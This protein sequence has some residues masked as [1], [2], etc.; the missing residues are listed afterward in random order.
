MVA[1]A[2]IY[3]ARLGAINWPGTMSKAFLPSIIASDYGLPSKTHPNGKITINLLFF[4]KYFAEDA[5]VRYFESAKTFHY[6][7]PAIDQIVQVESGRLKH[8][9]AIFLMRIQGYFP[10]IDLFTLAQPKGLDLLEKALRI[11]ASTPAPEQEDLMITF[12]DQGIVSYTGGT[13]TSDE[14]FQEFCRFCA[15]R[16][17]APMSRRLFDRTIGP[18]L[19]DRFN[20]SRTHSL[21]RDGSWRR[22]YRNIRVASRCR[23]DFGTLGTLGT[24]E[25]KIDDSTVL[26]K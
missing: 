2:P 23:S 9:L 15:A 16:N 11:V 5:T 13:A 25:L 21:V 22:G 26:T 10:H 1:K 4:A 20:V 14:L 19:R 6:L 7:D 18:V 8:I 3:E 24:P 17:V 12:L